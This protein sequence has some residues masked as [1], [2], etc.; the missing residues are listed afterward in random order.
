MTKIDF[1]TLSQLASASA[2]INQ[3]CS[4][5]CSRVP[6]DAWQKLPMTLEL[7]KFEEVGTLVDDPYGDPTFKEYHPH[8]THYDSDDAP[9]AP[10]Y[11]PCNISQVARCMMCGRHF[12]RYNEAGGYFTELRIRALR[13]QLLVDAAL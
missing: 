13:P 6:L 12:L 10:R 4:C 8:G 2:Q 5:S 11:Y 1:A 9:L 3:A 7:D